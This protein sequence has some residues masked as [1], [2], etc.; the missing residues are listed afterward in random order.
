MDRILDYKN[1][2]QFSN[3]IRN[4][5]SFELEKNQVINLFKLEK[6]VRENISEEIDKAIQLSGEACKNFRL[7]DI[8]I[9]LNNKE[10]YI[11]NSRDMIYKE[12]DINIRPGVIKVK[13][14]VLP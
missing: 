9:Y 6:N 8:K 14:D 2:R 7:W 13:L 10:V 1:Y 11:N 5:Y 3:F 12:K 4:G